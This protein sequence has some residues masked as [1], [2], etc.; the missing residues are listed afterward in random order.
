M[1]FVTVE[2]EHLNE[3]STVISIE[4]SEKYKFDWRKDVS[5]IEEIFDQQLLW[6]K[7]LRL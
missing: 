3:N 6:V 5:D 2:D 7:C 1:E 4:V